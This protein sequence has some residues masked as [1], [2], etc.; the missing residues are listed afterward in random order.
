MHILSLEIS[1]SPSDGSQT[2]RRVFSLA[3]SDLGSGLWVISKVV[4][5]DP[6]IVNKPLEGGGFRL[7]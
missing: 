5:T 7:I 6:T 4:I 1:W 3:K 2:C